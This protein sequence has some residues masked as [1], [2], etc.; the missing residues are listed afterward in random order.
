[1]DVNHE[2]VV[3][4]Q[5]QHKDPR[6]HFKEEDVQVVVHQSVKGGSGGSVEV[7]P[8]VLFESSNITPVGGRHDDTFYLVLNFS[9]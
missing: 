4:N 7:A 8:R 9:Y 2:H 5:D 1:M 6:N 3:K